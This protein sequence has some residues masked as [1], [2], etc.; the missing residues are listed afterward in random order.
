VPNMAAANRDQP[1]SS[2][3]G[4]NAAVSTTINPAASTT[5]RAAAAPRIGNRGESAG[6]SA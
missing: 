4:R 5:A 1:A 6:S 2:L 3:T